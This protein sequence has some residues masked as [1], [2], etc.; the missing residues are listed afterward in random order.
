MQT[1]TSVSR[2]G[3]NWHY[4][5]KVTP[6]LFALL[7]VNTYAVDLMAPFRGLKGLFGDEDNVVVWQ[8]QGQYIKI[9][10]QD[11]DRDHKRAPKNDHPASI[12][13]PHI[14]VVL[15]SLQ[16]WRPE[17]SPESDRS[18]PLFTNEEVSLFSPMLAD[19]LT[20]AGPKQDVVFAFAGI[21]DDFSSDRNRTT[22]GR[23]FMNE[24][25]LNIIFG[26]ILQPTDG[27][28]DDISHYAKPHRAGKR[29]EPTSRDIVVNIGLGIRHYT[30][31]E[32][33]RVDWIMIDVPAMIAAYRGPE[34]ITPAPVVSVTTPAG[35]PLS[36]ENR[37]L[38]EELARLRKENAGSTAP[39]QAAVAL[40][41]IGNTQAA[42]FNADVSAN[43]Q[44]SPPAV[45][46]APAAADVQGRL[47]LLKELHDKGL[48]TDQE[49]DAKRKEIVDQI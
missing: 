36:K 48:I 28:A 22:A 5:L 18:V 8:G 24:G 17:D 21:H 31:F 7:T 46:A 35:D 40:P 26:D 34:I 33:P 1:L 30:V 12:S 41:Q 27:D 38:R 32:R 49:Y 2:A 19:A 16:A 11:W 20:K 23:M 43:R 13:A 45:T 47:Q 9:V 25:L 39:A 15:A 42:P 37:K 4:L 10:E 29:M 14:A 3:R 44:I 6:V